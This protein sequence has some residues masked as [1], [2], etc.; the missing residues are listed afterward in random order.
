MNG[1]ISENTMNTSEINTGVSLAFIEKIL[2]LG[3]SLMTEEARNERLERV[4]AGGEGKTTI[5]GQ[6]F[7]ALIDECRDAL[8][9]L[10]EEGNVTA[11][12]KEQLDAVNSEKLNEV[13]SLLTS[14]DG[15]KVVASMEPDALVELVVEYRESV[16]KKK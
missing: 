2:G 1:N 3:L 7:A 14:I 9:L 11:V 15:K 4:V 5:D 10:V 6:A 12:S 13:K 8:R 16:V